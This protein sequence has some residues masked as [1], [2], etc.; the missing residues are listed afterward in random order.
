MAEAI[1]RIHSE[2]T[3]APTFFVQVVFEEKQTA[4]RFLGGTRA[5]GQIWISA[6]IRAG[7]T[8]AQRQKLMLRIMRKVSRIT[9][10]REDAVWIYLCN[11]APTDMIE[12]GHVLSLT[13]SNSFL[14]SP[15]DLALYRRCVRCSESSADRQKRS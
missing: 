2:E 7:R 12:Y 9:G 3:G 13:N 6:D 15:L 10:V 11:L 8:D 4:D 14:C 5:S 1:T